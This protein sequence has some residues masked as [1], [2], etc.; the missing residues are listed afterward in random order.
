MGPIPTINKKFFSTYKRMRAKRT[1]WA[2]RSSKT[3]FGVIINGPSDNY[4]V[5]SGT[6]LGF[7]FGSVN[8][9]INVNV[10]VN[11]NGADSPDKSLS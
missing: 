7:G 2:G 3:V 1:S 4:G 11:G 6:K 9:D 10:N 5:T 8:G